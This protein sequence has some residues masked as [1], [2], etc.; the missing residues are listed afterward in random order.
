MSSIK[1]RELQIELDLS[2]GIAIKD[3]RCKGQSIGL[4]TEADALF[5]FGYQ[6]EL[7]KSS[8][9]GLQRVEI[10]SFDET[11]LAMHAQ[12]EGFSF[13]LMLQMDG[14]MPEARIRLTIR[15]TSGMRR[16][17]RV[18]LPTLHHLALPG[19]SGNVL[20]CVSQELGNLDRFYSK[21]VLGLSPHAECGI[22]RGCNAV[23]AASVWSAEHGGLYF[24][25]AQGDLLEGA[26][27]ISFRT[28]DGTLVG[29]WATELSDGDEVALPEVIIGRIPPGDDWRT[30]V[31]RWLACHPNA[32]QRPEVP[33]WLRKCGALFAN[34]TDGAGGGFLCFADQGENLARQ[35][36]NFR[37]LPKMLE[38]ARYF[39]TD[40]VYLVDW[41]N[42]AN[43]AGVNT[44]ALPEPALFAKVGHEP[45]WNK[46]DY[47]PRDDLG[48]ADAL[49]E[50][51]RLTHAEGGRV[52]VYV[53][54]F[55]IFQHSDIAQAYG[56]QW[57][58][59]MPGCAP[60]DD[61]IYNY[62]MVMAH[63]PWQTYIA[64]QCERIVSDY[65]VDGIFLD[66]LGWQWN[67]LFH[68]WDENRSWTMRQ[69]NQGTIELADRV[70]KAIRKHKP[71]AV[72]LCESCTGPLIAHIDG[73]LTCDMGWARTGASGR[74]LAAPT[75]YACPHANLFSNGTTMNELQQF[76]AAGI[77]LALTPI[78]QDIEP[79]PGTIRKL[80][81]LRRE[82][83]D[84]L[85]DG[86]LVCQP[87]TGSITT[88][89]YL[90]RGESRTVLTI[91][92]TTKEA[93]EAEV[94]LPSEYVP[95]VWRSLLDNAAYPGDTAGVLCIH[96]APES[97]QV[98]LLTDKGA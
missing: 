92:H 34:R 37:A 10:D 94:R 81:S 15:N 47:I 39:G 75:R 49:K 96:M 32:M 80:I 59:R 30:G 83:S 85:V 21:G 17:A 74:L 20:A 51:I 70:R 91:C 97:L 87:D 89:A 18:Q 67:R 38:A 84:P 16:I 24:V 68:V 58:A 26:A 25:D 44:N 54:P 61:Y 22:P 77:N 71:D 27:A 79:V 28:E 55:I 52:I 41:Y 35:I 43:L 63:E 48:G 50:G 53:E 11:S 12:A 6:G 90:Y 23:N 13:R 1:G 33:A 86:E 42:P 82:Y 46:G 57:A 40:I 29:A 62:V 45:Y 65:D 14:T 93:F 56:A 98:L 8:R 72:V 2:Q 66:S 36:G 95:S 76:F 3:I 19:D 64:A 69:Y 7:L 5:A 60:A 4:L 78:W 73:G 31:D 88:P 9:E